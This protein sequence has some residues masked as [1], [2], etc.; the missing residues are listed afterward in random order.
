V[1]VLVVTTRWDLIGG[2]ERYAGAVVRGLGAAGCEVRVLTA[3]GE[4]ESQAEVLRFAALGASK[5]GSA[6]RTSLRS[7]AR[8][9]APD[10]V[11]LLSRVS[12][13]T[14]EVLLDVAPLVRFVQDHTLFCPGLNKLHEDGARCSSPLGLA[15][16]ERY[17]TGAGCSGFKRDGAPSLRYPLRSLA[18]NL[19]E[20]E[21]SKRCKH[22]LVASNYMR[23]ELLRA[24]LPAQLVS[25]VPYFTRTAQQDEAELPCATREF[26]ARDKTPLLLAPARLTLPDKG[27]DYLLTAFGQ[28]ERGPRLVVAGDGPARAWLEEKARD[29]GL[30]ERVHFTG[31]LDG[32]ELD[33]L[34][35]DASVV[36]FPSVW[37]E[38][39]GLVGLE[40]MS[41]GK[42]VVAFDVGGVRE[43]LTGGVTGLLCERRDARALARAMRELLDDPR[44]ARALGAVGRER[45]TQRFSEEEHLERLLRL[46]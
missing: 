9:F 36:L 41:H 5:L 38:P 3:E 10:V 25:V 33:A 2:S 19:R 21:L 26:L 15:C 29:E 37:D 30:A 28:L 24:G 18:A 46:L 22:V 45:A 20:L 11:Y 34:Y 27:I 1:R 4:Q 16:L 8:S 23:D 14:L 35:A 13:H 44:R 12:A 43:W 7:M 6:Q 17:Y 42:P 40:A 32:A 39:F 31:W